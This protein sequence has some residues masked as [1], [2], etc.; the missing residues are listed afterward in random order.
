MKGSPLLFLFGVVGLWATI[1]GWMSWPAALPAA[2]AARIR[3]AAPLAEPPPRPHAGPTAAT[4]PRLARD[5]LLA[6]DRPATPPGERLPPAG[7][8]AEIAAAAVPAVPAAAPAAWLRPQPLTGTGRPFQIASWAILRRGVGDPLAPGGQLA[9]SQAG[10]RATLPIAPP[11]AAALRLSGPLRGG[12]GVEAALGLDAR[13]GGAATL[14]VERRVPLDGQGRGAMA[15]TLFGGVDRLPLPARLEFSGFGQAGLVGLERR[16]GFV[17]GA[18]RIERPLGGGLAVGIGVWG[19][20]QPGTARLDL[21]P[22]LALRT[23]RFRLAAE[24][25]QRVAGAAR[26]GSGPVV[27]LGADF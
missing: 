12:P 26:P 1:R 3:W 20:A 5:P 4:A 11:V 27:T 9:G 23:G 21:G 10:L 7:S 22:S 16:A 13:L 6:A 14:A 8:A 17:D 18:A 19:G 2:P 25:R 24:W 15:I